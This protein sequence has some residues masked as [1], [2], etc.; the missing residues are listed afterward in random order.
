MPNWRAWDRW[1]LREAGLM[2]R[3]QLSEKWTVLLSVFE[4]K[5]FPPTGA[6]PM[7]KTEGVGSDHVLSSKWGLGR[8]IW[9]VKLIFFFPILLL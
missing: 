9:G 4:L 5:A 7:G 2:M 8:Q 1:G 3:S 6:G